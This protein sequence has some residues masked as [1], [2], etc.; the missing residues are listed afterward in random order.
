MVEKLSQ[1]KPR[2]LFAAWGLYWIGLI[3]VT[4]GR[5]I[6]PIMRATSGKNGTGSIGLSFDNSV[7]V[8][9][10]QKFGTTIYTGSADLLTIALWVAVPPL[11]LFLLWLRAAAKHR[12]LPAES[13]H[14]L[15]EPLPN[16]VISQRERDESRRR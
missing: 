7:F 6:E 12:A 2:K 5:A 1:W 4:L 8:L 10:V 11:I 15:N 16:D 3:G 14:L 9:K 13:A